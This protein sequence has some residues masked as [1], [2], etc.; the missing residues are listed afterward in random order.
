MSHKSIKNVGLV[1]A[2]LIIIILNLTQ[3]LGRDF[4]RIK[5]KGQ[6]F[7]SVVY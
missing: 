4:K 1:P 5:D 7:E 3:A 6:R 2:F